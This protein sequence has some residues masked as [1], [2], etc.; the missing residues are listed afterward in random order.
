MMRRNYMMTH[1]SVTRA[2]TAIMLTL[3]AMLVTVLV[4]FRGNSEVAARGPAKQQ[5]SHGHASLHPLE[6]G[7]TSASPEER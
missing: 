5:L 3:V 7:S 2:Q 6:T 4:Q 1:K